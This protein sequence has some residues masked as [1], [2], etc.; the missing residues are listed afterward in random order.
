MIKIYKNKDAKIST[1]YSDE[2]FTRRS[3]IRKRRKHKIK[4]DC[5]R[6]TKRQNRNIG[7]EVKLWGK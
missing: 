2:N 7:K 3:N 1:K 5:R 4:E 6:K